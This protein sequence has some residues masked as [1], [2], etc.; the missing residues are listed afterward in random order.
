MNP[1]MSR[2]KLEPGS[3]VTRRQ[4]ATGLIGAMAV[5]AVARGQRGLPS[6]IVIGAGAS[7]LAAARRLRDAGARV[8]VLEARE[9]RGGR[10]WT[11]HTLGVPIDLGAAWIEGE[12][13]PAMRLARE[14][15]LAT[16][17][18]D[19]D[20]GPV[21]DS[22]G[23]PIAPPRIERADRQWREIVRAMERRSDNVDRDEPLSVSLD[24][25]LGRLSAAD[26]ALVE[27]V[28]ITSIDED[29]GESPQRLSLL[30][31]E[32]EE[33]FGGA[34][35]ILPGGYVGVID[36]LARGLD[37]RLSHAARRVVLSSREVRVETDRGSFSADAC[38]V[39][40]PLALLR[41]RRITF[42]P[43]LPA[44]HRA[45]ID[46]LG[47][48]LLDKIALRFAR[49]FWPR[50]AHFVMHVPARR[51]GFRTFLNAARWSGEP[52]LVGLLG[53]DSA[54]SFER[55]DDN[56]ATALAMESLRAMFGRATEAPTRAIVTRWGAD[57]WALGA[58]SC[59]PVGATHTMR[60]QLAEPIDGRLHLAGEA[61]DPRYPATVHGALRSGWAAADA[62]LRRAPGGGRT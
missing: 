10:I 47:V 57:P 31:F 23:R 30:A 22:A 6:V 9:R 50:E 26:R 35:R 8:T 55:L 25:A 29:L 56:A 48:G 61:T 3:N 16:D 49:R 11:D 28:A 19:Y 5:P 62:V 36:G 45:V 59:A 18:S 34:H 4:F 43:A 15:R 42:D 39:T 20:H 44:R 32:E 60:E 58:Y 37:I 46:R 1:P 53:A 13:G 24:A 54:R 2:R 7:G 17:V 52:V 41:A 27:H 21:F 51:E 12:Q 38:I 33:E 14:F 40:V